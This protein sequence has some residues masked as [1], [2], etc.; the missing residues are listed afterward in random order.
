MRFYTKSHRYYGGI[1][2]HARVLYVCILDT[3]DQIRMHRNIPTTSMD[4]IDL[5]AP[6]LHEDVGICH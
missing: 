6:Y 3:E 4:L 1:D 2:L 5:L